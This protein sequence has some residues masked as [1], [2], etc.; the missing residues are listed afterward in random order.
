MLM[1]GSLLV[2]CNEGVV[3]D[4]VG[5]HAGHWSIG[6]TN[7]TIVYLCLLLDV[8]FFFVEDQNGVFR[9]A[10]TSCCHVVNAVHY[11]NTKV[12][13]GIICEFQLIEVD[14]QINIFVTGPC[15]YKV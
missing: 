6:G 13:I 11:I 5:V 2:G 10:R 3:G 4:D 15:E 8:E 7:R 9:E 14:G 1:G 12:M